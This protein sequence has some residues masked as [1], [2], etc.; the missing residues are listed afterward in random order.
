M[1]IVERNRDMLG[2]LME[3]AR[4]LG[5]T[6]KEI[7][8]ADNVNGAK[9]FLGTGLIERVFTG[10]THEGQAYGL[11]VMWKAIA[12]GISPE[13][14]AIGFLQAAPPAERLVSGVKVIDKTHP[15]EVKEFMGR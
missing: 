7:Y 12:A 6:D 11:D 8:G 13:R 5:W 2:N 3:L 9:K 10:F 1:L 15:E 4:G 14:I